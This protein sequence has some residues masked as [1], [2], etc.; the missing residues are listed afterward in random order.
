M[1]LR[2][3]AAPSLHVGVASI[4]SACLSVCLSVCLTA[5]KHVCAYSYDIHIVTPSLTLMLTMAS[6]SGAAEPRL[7]GVK[8]RRDA[9][10]V[11]A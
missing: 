10:S 5:Y 1:Q 11:A 6:V 3:P 8:R 7:D 2:A 9:A 4:L